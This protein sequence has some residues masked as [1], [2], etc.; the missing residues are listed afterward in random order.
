MHSSLLHPLGPTIQ[1]TPK[2]LPQA[3]HF[4]TPFCKP[5]FSGSV[6]WMFPFHCFTSYSLFN[7]FQT[8]SRIHLYQRWKWPQMAKFSSSPSFKPR[9]I[10]S[11]LKFFFRGF[12]NT[13]PAVLSPYWLILS[14]P[15]LRI[16]CFPDSALS[17]LWFW[18][19]EVTFIHFR[20][21]DKTQGHKM[22]Q[23]HHLLG[24]LG[25]TI[26]HFLVSIWSCKNKHCKYL[27]SGSAFPTLY[28]TF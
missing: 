16:W 22:T 13:N 23:S 11:F 20:Y 14:L 2:T 5:E 25:H 27:R 4:F 9:D 7:H 21:R 8:S 19:N 6:V 3:P 15:A 18:A 12:Y 28:Y 10:S 1:P 26:E 24:I 17:L